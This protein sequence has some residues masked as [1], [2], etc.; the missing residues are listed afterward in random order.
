MARLSVSGVLYSLQSDAVDRRDVR[1][2]EVCRP[3]SAC[4]NNGLCQEALNERGHRCICA[5]GFTGDTCSEAG[6]VCYPGKTEITDRGL[7]Y[8]F[9]RLKTWLAV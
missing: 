6:Q 1:Q 9:L 4:E 7:A 2:C 5:A 3:D 8:V